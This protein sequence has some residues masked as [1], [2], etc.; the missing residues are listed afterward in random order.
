MSFTMKTSIAILA[1]MLFANELGYA[2]TETDTKAIIQTLD[3]W[4]KGWAQNNA[5]LAIQDYAE[6]VDWTN[7]FGDRFKSRKELK[8]G[9]EYIFSLDFVMA[10]D[11]G[12]NEYEDVTFL[13]PDVALLRSKLVRRGQKTASGKIMPDRHNHHLRVLKRVNGQWKIVSHLISQSHKKS[14]IQNKK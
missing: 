1:L 7:A 6:D 10:G 9:L 8:K 13:T 3:S 11:S 2:Q 14:M 4:N 5:L 12:E